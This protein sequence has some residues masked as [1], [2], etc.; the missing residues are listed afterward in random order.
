MFRLCSSPAADVL[1]QGRPG[2]AVPV[3]LVAC[4]LICV[5]QGR[6]RRSW[7][8]QL[9]SSPAA[10]MLLQG[11]PGGAVPVMLV[12]CR[13][14]CVL[15]GRPGRSCLFQLCS[16]P[17]VAAN[18]MCGLPIWCLILLFGSS[19]WRSALW[20][21][22]MLGCSLMLLQGRPGKSAVAQKCAAPSISV[23]S[24]AEVPR[25]RF[26]WLSRR[27]PEEVDAQVVNAAT[28]V[29]ADWCVWFLSNVKIE[30]M[31]CQWVLGA[32][33]RANEKRRRFVGMIDR[34]LPWQEAGRGDL[35]GKAGRGLAW[36]CFGRQGVQWWGVPLVA[37]CECLVPLLDD[38]E[39]TLVDSPHAVSRCDP[40]TARLAPCVSSNSRERRTR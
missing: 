7:L 10:D 1:L 14:M 23:V 30:M 19:R 33:R 8:F 2:G 5:L 38:K 15:Q 12:A 32:N 34:A 29:K 39:M 24:L 36:G 18:G 11:R 25:P 37:D 3:M 27:M 17:A 22:K 40:A 13:L 26:P 4:R 35:P 6:P 9:C 31:S 20:I 16:S 28:V 21:R